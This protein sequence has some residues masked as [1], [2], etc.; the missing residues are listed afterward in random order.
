[1]YRGYQNSRW[2]LDAAGLVPRGREA[3]IGMALVDGQLVA[4][5]K[6]TLRGALVQFA[7]TPYRNLPPDEVDAL[8]QAAQRY[9]AFLGLDAHMSG[10]D[11]ATGR[12]PD[13]DRTRRPKHV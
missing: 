8:H 9:A 1:M 2:V 6:R 13:G 5:M 12:R 10:L 4:G 3:A 11:P 7:L